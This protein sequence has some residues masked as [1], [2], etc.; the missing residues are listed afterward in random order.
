MQLNDLVGKHPD[1]TIYII[2]TGPTMR[3]YDLS[4]FKDKLTIGL[5]QAYKYLPTTYSLTIHP[6]L[7]PNDP[8]IWNTKWITKIKG[9]FNYYDYCYLFSSSDGWYALERRISPPTLFVGR[10]IHTGGLHLA[11]LLG[12]K[13][14]ILCGVDMSPLG[15]EHHAHVQHNQFHKIPFTDVYKEY[16][17]YAVK[18][19]QILRDYWGMNILKMSPLLGESYSELDYNRLK[20]ELNLEDLPKPIEIEENVRC[21]NLISD[22]I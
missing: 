15:G 8:K 11:A 10:G 3:L 17:Y 13:T 20:K 19:R 2:G 22:F 18:C 1:S 6:N 4:F 9:K 16:Y 21:T 12:A 5:N 7:I 14:V